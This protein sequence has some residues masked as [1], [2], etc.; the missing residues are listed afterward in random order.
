MTVILSVIA[1]GQT[2]Y[3]SV[4]SLKYDANTISLSTKQAQV[5]GIGVREFAYGVHFNLVPGSNG[6]VTT[7]NSYI[8]FAD[9]GVRNNVYDSPGSCPINSTSECVE[10]VSLSR[11]NSI[12]SLCVILSTDI[13]DVGTCSSIGRVDVT[14]LRPS[15]DA[16]MVFFDLSGNQIST[17]PVR[18]AR[19]N[20]ISLDG[21]TNSIIIYTTGQISVQ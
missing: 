13:T 4:A 17:S 18:G 2:K 20:L 5:Y 11:G 19:I 1:L 10:S 7:R 3:T 9:R 14:F 6:Q 21:R 12:N 16:R 15:T 8:F